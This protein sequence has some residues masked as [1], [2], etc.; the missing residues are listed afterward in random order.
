MII[1]VNNYHKFGYLRKEFLIPAIM[2]VFG[3]VTMILGTVST[4]VYDYVLIICFAPFFFLQYTFSKTK[5]GIVQK[6]THRHVYI[7]VV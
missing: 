5:Y 4:F 6:K 3:V 7:T 2:V 1:K